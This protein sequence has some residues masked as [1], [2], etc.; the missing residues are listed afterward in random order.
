MSQGRAIYMMQFARHEE[1]PK[2]V[3][4]QIIEAHKG[5]KVAA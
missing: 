4:K 2:A 5:S 3:Q 1:A